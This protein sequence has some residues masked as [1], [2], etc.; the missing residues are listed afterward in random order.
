MSQILASALALLALASFQAKDNPQYEYWASCKAGSWVK[1]RME[2]DNQGQKIEYE[3]VT[4]LLEVTPEKVVVETLRRMK[5]GDKTIDSPPQ[6]SEIKAKDA[7]QGTTV[8]EKDE[9]IVVAG[10]TLKCRYYEVETE[11]P[12]KKR[13]T[14][15]AWMSK[16]IPGG[17]AKSEVTSAQLKGPI[18]V[19]AL[20]WEKK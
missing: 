9:E 14:V 6:K 17:A 3:S 8:S 7:Q 10:K 15:K 20:E 12:D 13:T 5:T 18:R 2:F 16:E 19:T 11:T 4:R 1:N